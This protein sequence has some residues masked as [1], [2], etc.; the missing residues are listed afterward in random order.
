MIAEGRNYKRPYEEDRSSLTKDLTFPIIPSNSLMN[1]PIV[2]EGMIEGH[3]IRRIHVDSG[4]S[5]EITYK[6]CFRSFNINI[7]SRLRICKALLVG[8]SGE[9]YHPLGLIDLWVTMGEIRRNKAV[10]MEFAIVKCRSPYNVQMGRTGM[11]SLRA[12]VLTI[13]SMIK[14]L[15]D[16]G[17]VTM[18]TSREAL[19]ECRKLEKKLCSWE[20]TQ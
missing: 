12:V 5:S 13:H 19:W 15:K 14:F 4:S 6:H 16:Q 9:T 8:F 1:E 17:V 18:E 20:E 3:Q 11:R 2:L 7:R 10:L